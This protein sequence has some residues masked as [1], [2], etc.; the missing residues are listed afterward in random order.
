MLIMFAGFINRGSS[1]SNLEIKSNKWEG[2][3]TKYKHS[4]QCSERGEGRE[5]RGEKREERREERDE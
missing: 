1:Y 2:N 4:A 5:E 3:V